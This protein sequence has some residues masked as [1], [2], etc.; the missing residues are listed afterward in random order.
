MLHSL[1]GNKIDSCKFKDKCGEEL[2]LSML[3]KIA[4]F[5]HLL[6]FFK[7]NFFKKKIRNTIIESNALD[8][9]QVRHF[10]GLDLDPSHLQR[11]SADKVSK[12][13]KI[14]NRYNH[15]PHLTQ[16]TNGKVTNS[17]LYTTNESQEV[18]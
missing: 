15:V 11:L 14:R 4:C 8:P 3:G 2:T 6:I 13:T 7:I 1:P 10:V 16:D 17:Q 12:G 5:C 9:D 18:S